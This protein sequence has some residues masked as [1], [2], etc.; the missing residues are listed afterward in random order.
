MIVV[1]SS[2]ARRIKAGVQLRG[3]RTR[4]IRRYVVRL[5]RSFCLRH[6]ERVEHVWMVCVP[7]RLVA[8]LEKVRP[9]TRRCNEPEW[10][11]AVLLS[12]SGFPSSRSH[13][14]NVWCSWADRFMSWNVSGSL[15]L[16]WIKRWYSAPR[17]NAHGFFQ[18]LHSFVPVTGVVES[19][20]F[21]DRQLFPQLLPPP[22]PLFNPCMLDEEGNDSDED[23]SV[24]AVEELLDSLPFNIGVKWLIDTC[25]MKEVP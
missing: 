4:L 10:C 14:K 18:T 1:A 22:V 25:S 11:F 2:S 16:Y 8:S 24:F 13:E 5:T 21:E 20:P 7:A 23:D 12:Y 17:N 15:P 9:S 6:H 3:N 19:S